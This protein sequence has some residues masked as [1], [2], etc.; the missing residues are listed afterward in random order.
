MIGVWARVTAGFGAT[1][2]VHPKPHN[3]V[4]FAYALDTPIHSPCG[5][6]VDN[7]AHDGMHSFGNAVWIREPDG[8]RIVFGHL[9]RVSVHAGERIH[10]GD[11]IGLSGNSGM[12]TGPHLHL[13]V[14]APNG[15]WIDPNRYF[16]PWNA[17]HLS[18][19]RL[20]DA[21]MSWIGDPIR[22]AIESAVSDV[23]RDFAM[24]LLHMVAPCA[25][26]VCATACLG[27]IVGLVKARRVALYSAL[28]AS[29]GYYEG[30]AS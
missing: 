25:L 17:L 12:S 11:V 21:E 28:L 6:V 2:A 9:D 16:S 30:W 24:W 29:I 27:V 7:V 14:L 15:Q 3:G 5:G 13:G 1:D 8:Y 20:K 10:A 23:T 22:H 4:Y 19:N 18:S 26:V